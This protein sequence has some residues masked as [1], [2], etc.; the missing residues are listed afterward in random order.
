MLA[1][2][3]KPFTVPFLKVILV[4]SYVSRLD[5]V[6]G[7][8]RLRLLWVRLAYLGEV[9]HDCD[10]VVLLAELIDRRDLDEDVLVFLRNIPLV[11]SER[12]NPI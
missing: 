1:L 4:S 12:H 11:E 7:S 2:R 10:K 5:D 9:G 8:G 3:C 6:H